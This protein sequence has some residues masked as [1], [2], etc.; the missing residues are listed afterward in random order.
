MYFNVFKTNKCPQNTPVN[1]NDNMR[2][3]L[4]RNA[5]FFFSMFWEDIIIAKIL[6]ENQ[7]LTYFIFNNLL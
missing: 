7:E 4:I 5:C 6:V 3:S 1:R 2:Q